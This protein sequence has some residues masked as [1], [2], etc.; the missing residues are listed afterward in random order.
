MAKFVCNNC[1]KETETK[2]HV[3]QFIFWL[4][5]LALSLPFKNRVCEKCA[6]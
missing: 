1:G 3:S 4:A 2:G 6:E 5:A